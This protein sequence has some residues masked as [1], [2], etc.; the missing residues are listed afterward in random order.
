M[1][2]QIVSTVPDRLE[3]WE[4]AFQ[5]PTQ[6]SESSMLAISKAELTSSTRREIVQSVASK[7]LNHCKYPTTDQIGVVA[8]KIVGTIKGSRDSLGTGHVSLRNSVYCYINSP[9]NP[10]TRMGIYLLI[11]FTQKS[12]QGANLRYIEGAGVREK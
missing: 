9:F 3:G 12:I 10:F 5:V 6:Y 4:D 7:M 1:A 8:S 11:V 2:L